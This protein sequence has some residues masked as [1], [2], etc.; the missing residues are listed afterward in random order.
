MLGEA[1]KGHTR[2]DFVEP[3]RLSRAA[4]LALAPTFVPFTR[5]RRCEGYCD[6]STRSIALDLVEHVAPIQLAI[7]LLIPEG[8]RLLE[9]D[10]VRALAREFD[11]RTLTYPWA[12]PDPAVDALQSELTQMIGVTIVAAARANCSGKVWDLAHAARH[13]MPRGRTTA[14]RARGDPLLQRALVLLSGAHR[15][16]VGSHISRI[17]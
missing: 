2:A 14:R 3:W 7:R 8:S 9:L 10:D 1:R 6:C 17:G 5:G 11:P 4:G 12:H 15:R 16:A 13:A